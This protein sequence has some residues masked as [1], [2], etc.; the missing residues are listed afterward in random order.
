[1][2]RCVNMSTSKLQKSSALAE[3]NSTTHYIILENFEARKT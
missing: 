2:T 3:T 1:M